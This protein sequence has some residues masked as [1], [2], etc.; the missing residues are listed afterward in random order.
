MSQRL[1]T[2][3]KKV[4]KELQ[5]ITNTKDMAD[6]IGLAIQFTLLHD[7]DSVQEALK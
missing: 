6:A 4:V 7:K 2:L 3:P 1:I 5:D